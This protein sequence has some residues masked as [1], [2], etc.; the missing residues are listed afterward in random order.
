LKHGTP[1]II[2]YAATNAQK[3][4][5]Q[6]HLDDPFAFFNAHNPLTLVRNIVVMLRCVRAFTDVSAVETQQYGEYIVR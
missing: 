2:G 1:Q 4:P 5:S 3:R 6:H